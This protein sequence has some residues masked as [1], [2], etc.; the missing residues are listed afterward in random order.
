M[1][2]TLAETLAKYELELA[3]PA[4]SQLERYC[5]VLWAWNRQLN[6]TRHTDYE[7]FVT[8]DIY[9]SLQLAQQL[10]PGEEVLDVGSGGGVPGIPLAVLRPD[11]QLELSESV[12]KRARALADIV[13]QLNLPIPV[14]HGRAE[15]ILD[16]LRFDSLTIRA[17]SPL[18]KILAWFQPKWASF[19]RL[20]LIKGPKWI[21]ERGEARHQGLMQNLQLRKLASYTAPT[22]AQSV[23]LEVRSKAASQLAASELAD[24]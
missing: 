21:D 12:G 13:Q 19:E 9:D 14:H 17:V 1:S 10:A 5:D 20:L 7:R 11:L 23:I 8:R 3:T 15:D 24:M 18:N 16:D 22:G 2:L 6:L 4:I